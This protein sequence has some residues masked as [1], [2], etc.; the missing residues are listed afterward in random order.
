MPIS[1]SNTSGGT[2]AM[3]SYSL[4]AINMGFASNGANPQGLV[5]E[6][7]LAEYPFDQS[8]N[9]AASASY[10]NPYANMSLRITYTQTLVLG[11]HPV[12][13]LAIRTIID[14]SPIEA[15]LQRASSGLQ[16]P[17]TK[18]I[19]YNMQEETIKLA[20]D[21]ETIERAKAFLQHIMSGISEKAGSKYLLQWSPE[22]ESIS[23]PRAYIC[24]APKSQGGDN[25]EP[26]VKVFAIKPKDDGELVRIWMNSILP[27]LPDILSQGVGGTY[28][29]SLVRRGS[30]DLTANPCIQIESPYIPGRENRESIEEALKKIC[31]ANGQ[32]RGIQVLFT[33]GR[34]QKL[35]QGPDSDTGGEDS[36]QQLL[37]FNFNLNRPCTKP[38]MGASLGLMCSTKVSGTLGGYILVDDV[39]YIL[40]SDHFVERSR[41]TTINGGV[42][43]ENQNTLVSPSLADLAQM[44]EYLEQT[45]RDFKAKTKSQWQKY[46][47]DRDIQPSDLDKMLVLEREADVKEF[48]NIRELLNQVKKPHEDFTLGKVFRRS[49]D[50]RRALDAQALGPDFADRA[51]LANLMRSMDWAMCQVNHRAGENRPKYRSNDDAKADDYIYESTRADEAGEI[52]HEICD[53]DPAAQVYYVGQKSG[54]REGTVNG[55]P[56]LICNNTVES[57]EWSILGSKGQPILRQSVEGDSGAWVIRKYDNQLMGQVSAYSNDQIFFTTIK[58]IFADIQDQF[59]MVSLPA[60]Q[61][62]SRAAAIPMPVDSLCSVKTELEVGSYRWLIGRP[63]ATTSATSSSTPAEFPREIEDDIDHGIPNPRGGSFSSL[64]SLTN[65]SASPVLTSPMTPPSFRIAT[66]LEKR[67]DSKEA[68]TEFSGPRISLIEDIE[69][70]KPPKTNEP[71]LTGNTD[72]AN[73]EDRFEKAVI[74]KS[75][76]LF[77]FSLQGTKLFGRS[78]TWPVSK[79]K[80][81]TGARRQSRRC[82]KL[83]KPARS[84]CNRRFPVN[85][86]YVILAF[87]ANAPD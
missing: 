66:T 80:K 8:L 54:H 2:E 1:L 3:A 81:L 83:A 37:H 62:T 71:K 86:W 52:C 6:T 21:A 60:I 4:D 85:H 69:D 45:E 34:L 29:A 14:F 41:D 43:M 22:A 42:V 68:S 75:E 46:L 36:D 26:P 72:F 31:H 10:P 70:Q 56:S 76:V 73:A 55:V 27:A 79:P 19:T 74:E 39:K 47:G 58:D 77:L 35:V 32:R 30:S 40:T 24:D 23:S 25:G 63:L 5:F 17:N 18:P 7:M 13:F 9:N 61:R 15:I 78:F 12:D 16:P 49:K 84:Y 51:N 38:G 50:P 59:D 87:A 57:H 64:P 33:K 48:K 11:I 65:S 20:G 28:A 44:A 53:I 67:L 82:W